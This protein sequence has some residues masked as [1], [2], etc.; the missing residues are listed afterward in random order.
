VTGTVY[1]DRHAASSR[2]IHI[3]AKTTH[4]QQIRPC[5]FTSTTRNRPSRSHCKALTKSSASRLLSASPSPTSSFPSKST[6][7]KPPPSSTPPSPRT[8]PVRPSLPLPPFRP[9]H[10][11]PP[12]PLSTTFFPKQTSTRRAPSSRTAR[13]PSSVCAIRTALSPST[14]TT[15]GTASSSSR[16]RPGRRPNTC[17]TRSLTPS[18]RHSSGTAYI[19]GLRRRMIDLRRRSSTLC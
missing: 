15:A 17:A 4:Q 18:R 11:S 6:P 5:H 7:P 1:L 16:S 13:R 19:V 2:D 14:S 8:F 12:F 3:L 9:R 10:H